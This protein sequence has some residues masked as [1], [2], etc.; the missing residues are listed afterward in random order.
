MFQRRIIE[1]TKSMY[2]DYHLHTEFSG[3]CTTPLRDLIASAKA[4]GLTEICITDHHDQDFPKDTPACSDFQLDFDRYFP[5]LMALREELL[6]R[7]NL[8]I[9]IEQGIMPSTCETMS[10]FSERYPCLDFIICSTHVVDGFDP[11][12]PEYFEKWGESEGYRKYF[13][14]ILYNVTHFSDYNVYGHLDYILRYGPTKADNFDVRDYLEIFEA[15][16]RAIIENGKGIE[17]NTGSLY[18]GMDFAHPHPEL[19]KLYREMGGEIIT[20]GSDAH[21]TIHVGHA[22][23]QGATLLRSLGFRYYCTF[24]ERKAAFHTL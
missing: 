10:N 12:Y 7:F 24:W 13:E 2:P 21:D 9:G 15:I 3:D 4:K 17:L 6:P 16:F 5:A 18:R 20:F 1:R 8:K 19:L 14:D 22:F 11:Y 23:D